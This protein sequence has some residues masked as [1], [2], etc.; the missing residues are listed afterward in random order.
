[1]EVLRYIGLVEAMFDYG[2]E[3]EE[4]GRDSL[5]SGPDIWTA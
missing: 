5:G 3:E 1:M 4:M 2:L